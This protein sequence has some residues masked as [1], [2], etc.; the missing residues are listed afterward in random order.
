[1][2]RYPQISQACAFSYLNLLLVRR[3]A[4]IFQRAS[5]LCSRVVLASQFQK[6]KANFLEKQAA[7]GSETHTEGFSDLRGEKGTHFLTFTF[8]LYV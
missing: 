8:V 1:M 7:T 6:N 5:S 4:I 2:H 3:V